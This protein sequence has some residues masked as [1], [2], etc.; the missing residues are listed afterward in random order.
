MTRS[1]E[2]ITGPS[3]A[4]MR[5]LASK[6]IS[7]S[8]SPGRFSIRASACGCEEREGDFRPP[9]RDSAVR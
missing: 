4:S 6:S 9:F 3:S 7:S 5:T 2:R 8:P 1:S